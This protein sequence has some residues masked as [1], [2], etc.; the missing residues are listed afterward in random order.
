MNLNLEQKQSEEYVQHLVNIKL[1][2]IHL[3][4]IQEIFFLF[5]DSNESLEDA[6]P[7]RVTSKY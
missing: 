5:L 7:F 4:E 2:N 3:K 6:F 1:V